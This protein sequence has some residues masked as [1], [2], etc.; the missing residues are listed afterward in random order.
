MQDYQIIVVYLI[1]TRSFAIC[2]MLQ[3]FFKKKENISAYIE[4]NEVYT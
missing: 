4:A 2:L 3:V 1:F